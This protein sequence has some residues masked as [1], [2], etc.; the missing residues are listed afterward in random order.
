ME[1]CYVHLVGIIGGCSGLDNL[2]EK[3]LN[4]WNQ[5]SLGFFERIQG[6]LPHRDCARITS[7]HLQTR[8]FQVNETIDITQSVSIP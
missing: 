5:V 1:S 8:T 3:W 2:H 7:S 4:L 6:K